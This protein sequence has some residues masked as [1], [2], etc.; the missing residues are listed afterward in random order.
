MKA[1]EKLVYETQIRTAGAIGRAILDEVEN[2]NLAMRN[3][4][5]GL[6]CSDTIHTVELSSLS[7]GISV[8]EMV[9]QK[10]ISIVNGYISEGKITHPIQDVTG[11]KKA[12]KHHHDTVI[13]FGNAVLHALVKRTE[14]IDELKETYKEEADD[15]QQQKHAINQ[16]IKMV[17]EIMN[18]MLEPAA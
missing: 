12:T 5:A 4:R 15:L 16:V 11:P 10:I 14:E 18:R 3:I 1:T 8:L 9:S 13:V 7:A 17:T 6:G 2:Q